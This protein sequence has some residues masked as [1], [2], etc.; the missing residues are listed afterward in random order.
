M[1]NFKDS[2]SCCTVV[3]DDVSHNTKLGKDAQHFCFLQLPMQLLDLHVDIVTDTCD[4][5]LP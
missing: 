3:Y 4:V 5:M 1:D 2:K